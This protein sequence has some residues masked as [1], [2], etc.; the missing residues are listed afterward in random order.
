MIMLAHG[1]GPPSGEGSAA[2]KPGPLDSRENFEANLLKQVAC[3][4]Q[5]RRDP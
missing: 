2:K 4:W 5:G 3:V 1:A